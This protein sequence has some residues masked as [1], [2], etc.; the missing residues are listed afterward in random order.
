M[1]IQPLT[2]KNVDH[3]RV[4]RQVDNEKYEQSVFDSLEFIVG[5]VGHQVHQGEESYRFDY[6]VE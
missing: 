2:S 4:T 1:N 5:V 6:Q 3:K